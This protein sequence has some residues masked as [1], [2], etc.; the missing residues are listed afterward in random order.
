MEIKVD[1]KKIKGFNVEAE[2]E[3][4]S[5]T[6]DFSTDVIKESYR[7]ESTYYSSS[8][9]PQI[10]SNIVHTAGIFIRRGLLKPKRKICTIIL[11]IAAAVLS[12]IIG[13]LYN[14]ETLKRDYL[15]LYILAIAITL[16]V[17]IFSIFKED[18]WRKN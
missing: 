1:S 14:N 12:M 4:E 11:R 10:T 13:L 9:E 8:N 15:F 5:I 6:E 2:K 18:L 17:V 7:I 16:T 3:L